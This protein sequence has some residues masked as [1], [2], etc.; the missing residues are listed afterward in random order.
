M[1][2]GRPRLDGTLAAGFL[3]GSFFRRDHSRAP[4][5][6]CHFGF[7]FEKVDRQL[8]NLKQGTCLDW[9]G[10]WLLKPDGCGERLFRKL[11]K[12][13]NVLFQV[14]NDNI[15]YRFGRSERGMGL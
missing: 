5:F 1:F 10:G 8:R 2:A 3:G 12:Q 4:G 13:K 9:K 14:Q 7:P 6:F 11:K 15:D